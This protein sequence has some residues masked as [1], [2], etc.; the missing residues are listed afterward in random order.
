MN[1][2]IIFVIVMILALLAIASFR[3]SWSVYMHSKCSFE[4]DKKEVALTFDDGPERENILPLLELLDRR[5]VKATFF[6]I[7]K[8]VKDNKDI[9]SKIYNAG[10][11]IG[12]HSYSHS[13]LFPF[14]SL[15]RIA[16]EL[17]ETKLLLQECINEKVTLF[18]PPFG[19]TNPTIAYAVYRVGLKS[20]G[21][22]I[23]S[24]DTVTES[25]DKIVARIERALK[26]GSIILLHSHLNGAT[27]R[28]EMVLD[29]IE[30]NGYKVV[31]L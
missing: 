4:T 3:I 22:N 6:F 5:C 10:H 29:M 23:R 20:V 27:R 31:G 24:L 2:I 1:L 13:S 17:Y 26:P 28:T 9:V 12:V 18:R 30:K 7:G 21:W 14:Y 25:D 15:K 11:K 16:K 8:F 19:V